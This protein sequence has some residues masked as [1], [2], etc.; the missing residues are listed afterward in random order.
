VE[1]RCTT[2]RAGAARLGQRRCAR[3]FLGRGIAGHPAGRRRRASDSRAEI[4]RAERGV[5]RVTSQ[6]PSSSLTLILPDDPG[7]SPR[8]NSERHEPADFSRKAGLGHRTVSRRHPTLPDLSHALAARPSRD[9]Q[10]QSRPRNAAVRKPGGSISLNPH[11]KNRASPSS[12]LGSE[13]GLAWRLAAASR[14]DVTGCDV[15]E[16][17]VARFVADGGEAPRT[18]GRP[19][20]RSISSSAWSSRRADRDHSVRQGR[21]RRNA[22]RCMRVFI[23]LRDHR[24][25]TCAAAGDSSWKPPAGTISTRRSPAAHSAPRG[26]NLTILAFGQSGGLRQGKAALDAMAAKLIRTRACRGPGRRVQDRSIS[27]WPRAHRGGLEAIAFAARQGLDIRK[28]YEVITASAV[29][30]GCSRTACRMCSTAITPREGA[31]EYF[32]QGPAHAS[33]T[34]RARPKFPVPVSAAAL[35][36]VS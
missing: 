15:S 34:W 22:G 9:T 24:T 26:R 6:P 30:P 2:A 1:C 27:C 20:G 23:L 32:C 35:A 7:V 4:Q 25:R 28:V 11:R 17:A 10:E 16:D 19:P 29:I 18:P 12:G 5:G 8:S 31:V 3:H 21:R 13:W 33:R 14:F 36:D